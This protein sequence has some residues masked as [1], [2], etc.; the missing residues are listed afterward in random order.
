MATSTNELYVFARF[1]AKAGRE[2]DLH[3]ALDSLVAPTR[4]EAGNLQYDVF[5]LREQPAVFYLAEC[6]KDEAALAAHFEQPYLK[7][8]LAAIP[9]L[10]AEPFSMG[11]ASMVSESAG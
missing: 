10:Q 11:R 9:E 7:E 1:L 8:F 4:Q 2:E 6:W 5:R 3:R